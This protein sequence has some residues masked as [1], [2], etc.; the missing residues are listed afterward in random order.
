MSRP[1][2][3]YQFNT[4]TLVLVIAVL[5]AALTS[6]STNLYF[7]AKTLPICML[8]VYSTCF[9]CGL[10][11]LKKNQLLAF[12]VF[13]MFYSWRVLCPSSVSD[14]LY[15]IF[16]TRPSA[17]YPVEAISLRIILSEHMSLLCA[18]PA[19]AI[20]TRVAQ[21]QTVDSG[22]LPSRNS[23]SK[24]V[25]CVSSSWKIL[26]AMFLYATFV[27]VSVIVDDQGALWKLFI[28]SVISASLLACFHSNGAQQLGYASFGTLGGV[29]FVSST[30]LVP[31]HTTNAVLLF[32]Q[33]GESLN[34]SSFNDFVNSQFLLCLSLA[35]AFVMMRDSARCS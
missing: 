29:M 3:G 22:F 20:W 6:V 24:V 32:F 9:I 14:W 19:S 30:E 25:P 21:E 11:S 16:T 34:A 1:V 12:G 10:K 4:R 15:T 26:C 8:A 33:A 35:F 18:I 5:A 17:D 31:L 13:G 2:N 28:A 23:L 7:W 27:G